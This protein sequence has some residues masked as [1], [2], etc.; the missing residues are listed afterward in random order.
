MLTKKAY[1]TKAAKI[2][3]VRQTD[4]DEERYNELI[5]KMAKTNEYI[6]RADVVNLLHV[7]TSKAYQLLRKLSDEGRLEII[8]NG[9]YAKYKIV[10]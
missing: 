6:A 8:N 1:S 7:S 4:I 3:Y 2:G 5:M 9:H 10:N